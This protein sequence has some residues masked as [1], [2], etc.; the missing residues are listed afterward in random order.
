MQ[1]QSHSEPTQLELSESE[2]LWKPLAC[3]DLPLRQPLAG[4]FWV[5]YYFQ[6]LLSVASVAV[7]RFSAVLLPLPA[8][9][10]SEAP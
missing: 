5:S 8:P 9:D 2:S 4:L 3:P 7:L 10:E 6:P 1:Q